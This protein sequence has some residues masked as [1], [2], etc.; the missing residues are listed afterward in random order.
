MTNKDNQPTEYDA[1]LGGQQNN[2]ENNKSDKEEILD[3]LEYKLR[4]AELVVKE[5]DDTTSSYWQYSD[6]EKEL[7][8]DI[9]GLGYKLFYFIGVVR[10]LEETIKS[11]RTGEY[12][13]E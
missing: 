10:C 7:V 13:H 2:N 4:K 8:G 12:E 5:L 3:Y 1:V 9:I 11:I 6:Y